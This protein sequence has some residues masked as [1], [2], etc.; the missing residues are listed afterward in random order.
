MT[1]TE[2]KLDLLLAEVKFLQP[3]LLKLV[4]TINATNT[5][6]IDTDKISTELNH[7]IKDLT[8]RIEVLEA[9]TTTAPP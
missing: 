5:W 2:E 7:S 1:T 8:S 4:T 6:S 9:A 3:G